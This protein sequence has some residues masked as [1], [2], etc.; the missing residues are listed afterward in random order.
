MGRR[1]DMGR[2][3]EGTRS[4]ERRRS[5][6]RVGGGTSRWRILG[7]VKALLRREG[8]GAG[9]I[10]SRATSRNV[11]SFLHSFLSARLAMESTLSSSS[12]AGARSAAVFVVVAVMVEPLR[13]YTLILAPGAGEAIWAKEP[14]D[15]ALLSPSFLARLDYSAH[16]ERSINLLLENDA[17]PPGGECLEKVPRTARKDELGARAPL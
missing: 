10:S 12:F 11:R 5:R 14:V 9:A 4:E 1:E 16:V 13:L 2:M 15:R 8:R 17:E 6:S 3:R 7:R